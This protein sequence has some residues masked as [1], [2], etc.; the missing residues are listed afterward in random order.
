MRMRLFAVVAAVGILFS[1]AHAQVRT[2][3]AG[4][5]SIEDVVGKWVGVIESAPYRE[6]R[7][8]MLVESTGGSLTCR[9]DEPGRST[10][11]LAKR[12]WISGGTFNLVTVVETTVTMEL[13][14]DRKTL[15]GP[16]EPKNGMPYRVSLT[17][18]K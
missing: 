4:T 14:T 3:T 1:S 9:W 17:R 2:A 10:V 15:F 13:S 11:A 5:I 18:A 7:R 12:C 6:T 8:V 16:F